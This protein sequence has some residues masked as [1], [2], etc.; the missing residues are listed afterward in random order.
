MK[1]DSLLRLSL[2]GVTLT[3]LE[4]DPPPGPDGLSSLAEVSRLFFRELA[5]FKDGMF[6]ERDFQNLRGSF[7]KA[8]AYSHIRY[9]RNQLLCS[10]TVYVCTHTPFDSLWTLVFRVTGAA[11]QLAC[12]M[13]SAGRHTRATTSDLSF[14]RLELL[15]CLWD[16]GSPQYTEVNSTPSDSYTQMLSS[17]RLSELICSALKLT[18]PQ[19]SFCFKSSGQSPRFSKLHQHVNLFTVQIF[20]GFIFYVFFPSEVHS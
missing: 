15:E 19:I 14:S 8:C 17:L 11:V 10:P 6:S 7:A 1:P 9:N 13:R 5:F 18:K 2:G 20:K 3:L 4:Q 12:E 16:S